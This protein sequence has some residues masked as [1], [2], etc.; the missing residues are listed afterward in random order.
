MSELCRR[1]H[2]SDQDEPAQAL[3]AVVAL[4]SRLEALEREHVRAMLASGSSWKD[5]AAVLGITRQAAHR[6]FRDLPQRPRPSEAKTEVD[7]IL[8]TGDARSLVQAA[9]GEAEAQG[10]GRVGT[11]HLLLALAARAP[12]P[13]ATALW[14]VGVDEAK[15]RTMLQPTVVDEGQ[16]AESDD[17]FTRNAREVLEGA[18]REAVERGEGYIGPEH[19]LLALLRNP[20]G[21]AAQTFES[22]GVKPR[23]VVAA[24]SRN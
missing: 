7:R 12:E 24:L 6:R 18:L 16:P 17:R 5:V 22:L 20:S 19:L 8:V 4:R 14:D 23:A 15:L 13:V 2:G 3:S 11:E 21:G 9:R 1:A 10:S